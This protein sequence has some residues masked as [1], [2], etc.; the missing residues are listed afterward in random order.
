MATARRTIILILVILLFMPASVNS[1]AVVYRYEAEAHALHELGIYAGVNT[2]YFDP[3]LGSQVQRQTAVILL[4]KMFGGLEEALAMPEDEVDSILAPYIDNHRL[5]SFA[6]PFMAYAIRNGMVSGVSVSPKMLGP[7][8]LIDSPSLACMIL[9]NMGY[10]INS[11]EEF[12]LSLDTL[13][14]LGGM[15][16]E[17]IK[18]LNH[19]ILIKDDLVGILYWALRAKTADGE[20]LICRLIADEAI[21][22]GAVG[23]HAHIEYDPLT[24]E[25][26]VTLPEKPSVPTDREIIYRL[27][28]DAM[29]NVS[30]SV[31]LPINSASDTAGEIWE[32]IDD[33]LANT[34]QILYYSGAEYISSKGILTLK[35]SKD[36]ATV[37]KHMELLVSKAKSILD[38]I[39]EPGMTD[40]R[41]ELAIHDYIINNCRYDSGKVQAPESNTAYGVLCLGVAVCGGYS[42]A[43]QLL[44]QMAGVE[45]LIV[46]DEVAGHAWNIVRIGGE[47]YHLDVTW[48][49]PV[50]DGRDHLTYSYFNLTDKEISRDHDWDRDAYPACTSSTYNYYVYNGLIARDLDSFVSLVVDR[51]NSGT[52][53]ITVKVCDSKVPPFDMSEAANAIR[54]AVRKGFLMRPTDIN[55][56]V[57]LIFE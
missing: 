44:L 45:C 36:T 33:V 43:A 57:D 37:K 30:T 40:Y 42:E 13:G 55:G 2:R 35:Y 20:S 54:S 39:L 1:S 10:T 8:I 12:L 29:L 24:G 48:D 18:R 52:G 26:L 56:V 50:I 28:R 21:P 19:K 16:P 22:L 15:K 34:P 32:I 31:V 38:S 4:V 41:K 25:P 5:A 7:E 46:K 49:D 6:R 47:Y 14:A 17:E 3:D 9:K 53:F 11:S 51:V 23:E 27:I